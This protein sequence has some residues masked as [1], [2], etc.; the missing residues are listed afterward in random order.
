MRDILFRPMRASDLAAAA[1]L[2]DICYPPALRDS[3]PALRSRIALRDHCCVVG[4]AGGDLLGYILAH[5]W[6]TMAPPE[7]D[8]V[9]MQPE[10]GDLIHYVHDLSV[11][12]RWRSSGLGR[13]LVAMSQAI[14]RRAGL[15]RSE[16]IA[17]DGAEPYWRT[18]GYK[19]L[20]IDERIA[21]KVGSYGPAAYLG[22]SYEAAP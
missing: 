14:A 6:P 17:I 12:P 19:P 4:V 2:Q 3:G 9:L 18:L 13:K 22:R 5:P 1:R 7:P 10:D 16:L 21:R 20:P 8:M 11:D 15:N